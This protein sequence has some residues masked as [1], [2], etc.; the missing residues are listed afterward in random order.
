MADHADLAQLSGDHGTKNNTSTFQGQLV[1]I[2]ATRAQIQLA[3]VEEFVAAVVSV[4][5]KNHRSHLP[6][7]T[8]IELLVVISII[9]ILIALTLPAVLSAREAARKTQCR[10]NLKQIGI[11]FHAHSAIDP[12]E[13]FCTGQLDFV[14]DGCPDFWGWT[15]DAANMN[16][17]SPNTMRCPASPLRGSRT[18][19]DLLTLPANGTSATP[20]S[21]R[22]SEN[23]QVVC[24][25]PQ[26]GA[27]DSATRI[28][29]V[30]QLV[31][32]GHNS[33]YATSW[34]LG[35]SNFL[36]TATST[37]LIFGDMTAIS[38]TDDI[39]HTGLRDLQNT[40]GP[41]TLRYA[42]NCDI[43]LANIPLLGDAAPGNAADS[44]LS[45]TLVDTDGRLCDPGLS[46]GARL[47][48]TATDGPAY[49]NG[50]AIRRINDNSVE[51]LHTLHQR[52]PSPG[53][54]TASVAASYYTAGGSQL[55][56]QDTRGWGAVHSNVGLVLMA[57]G[58]VQE[59]VDLNRDGYFNPGFPSVSGEAATDGYI[60][61]VC[62]I[63]NHDIYC[64][65]SLYFQIY[66]KG[67]FE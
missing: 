42:D 51:V 6:G 10:N 8:L 65:A 55:Y 23:P 37:P 20:F 60:D 4:R 30:A 11:S 35:R 17:L 44:I 18:L 50:S 48:E 16:V 29:A 39:T 59:F 24:S 56:F 31:R 47:A 32:R 62:E 58:N 9:S 52:F 19:A 38:L 13:R 25:T 49:W 54:A 14:R 66:E 21:R 27:P 34:F 43:P 28:A 26:F 22:A 63:N 57:S 67:D 7:F 61:D 53:T 46:G 45:V 12:T 41:L 3:K 1:A 15:A 40:V 64:G 2:G 36:I 33:N 5:R